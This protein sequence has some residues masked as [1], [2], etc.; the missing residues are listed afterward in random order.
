LS[1]FEAVKTLSIEASYATNPTGFRLPT[2]DSSS[3]VQLSL[4]PLTGD[5]NAS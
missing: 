2:P 4:V 5:R 3:P 1:Q